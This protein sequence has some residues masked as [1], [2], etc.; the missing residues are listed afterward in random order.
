MTQDED[1]AQD[2]RKAIKLCI[3]LLLVGQILANVCLFYAHGKL[4]PVL[5][6][7]R[8]GMLLIPVF[9]YLMM[10]KVPEVLKNSAGIRRQAIHLADW[11]LAF[12]IWQFV[13]GVGEGP[14][15][16]LF[17]IGAVTI[18]LSVK[19]AIQVQA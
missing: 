7:P 15:I 5:T 1:L 12:S 2:T 6:D 16:A 19:D 8:I 14:L 11:W 13:A 18:A 17:M 9:V 3:C 10:T 4:A